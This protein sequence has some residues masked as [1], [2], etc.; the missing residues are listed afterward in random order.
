MIAMHAVNHGSDHRVN[1][2]TPSRL[3]L[4]GGLFSL[5]PSI[6]ARFLNQVTCLGQYIHGS[7]ALKFGR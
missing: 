2:Q 6:L 3:G 4:G 7:Y 5:S 1:F